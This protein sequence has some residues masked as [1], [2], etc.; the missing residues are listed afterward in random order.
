M[1]R[2][3]PLAQTARCARASALIRPVIPLVTLRHSSA[4][5]AVDIEALLSEPTW[6]VKTLLPADAQTADAPTIT[7]KQLRHLLNLSALPEP[8]DE[9]E[10]TKMLQTLRSQ[11]HFVRAIQEVDTK[12][13]PPLRAIRDETRAAE[14][15][16][17]ISVS[18]LK[19]ALEQE[20]V[21]G[22]HYKRIQRKEGPVDTKGAEDWDV[23]AHAERKAGKY[24]VVD[25][26]KT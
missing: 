6:S 11:L 14:D 3:R 4:K 7:S 10:E 12:S 9:A 24:F 13:V 16:N 20:E 21:R 26:G 18:S 22:K 19:K 8:K 17:K 2:I 1:S 5:T 25:S 15:E 23:L